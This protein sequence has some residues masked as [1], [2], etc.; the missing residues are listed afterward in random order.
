MHFRAHESAYFENEPMH[1][2]NLVYIAFQLAHQYCQFSF[3]NR[4]KYGPFKC[5][6]GCLEIAL[7]QKK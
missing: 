5:L 6:G 1:P 3:S 2:Q 7:V 4:E